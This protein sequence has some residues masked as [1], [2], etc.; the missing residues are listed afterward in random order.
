VPQCSQ[1]KDLAVK[2]SVGLSSVDPCQAWELLS[3]E[4]L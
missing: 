3:L 2:V 1:V 4:I